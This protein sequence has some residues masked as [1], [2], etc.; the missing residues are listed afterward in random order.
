MGLLGI[1]DIKTSLTAFTTSWD[2]DLIK[3]KLAILHCVL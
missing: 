2:I 1:D 3:E